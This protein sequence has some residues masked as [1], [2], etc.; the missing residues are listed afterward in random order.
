MP[1]I[2]IYIGTYTISYI[3]YRFQ[4]SIETVIKLN[5]SVIGFFAIF[6]LP[7]VIHVK[8]VYF[9]EDNETTAILNKTED[10]KE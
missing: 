7:F 9:S 8:C 4:I 3:L 5:G 10:K 6:L 2:V 1:E